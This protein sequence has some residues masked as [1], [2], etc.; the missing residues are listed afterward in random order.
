MVGQNKQSNKDKLEEMFEHFNDIVEQTFYFEQK[1]FELSNKVKKNKEKISKDMGRKGRVNVRVDD[2]LAFDVTKTKDAELSFYKSEL[3][4][5]L[6]KEKYKK[7]VNKTVKIDDLNGLIKLLKSYGI[8]PEE[9]K[10]YIS[11]NEEVDENLIEQLVDIGDIDIKDLQGCY[12]ADFSEEI[13]VRKI[14]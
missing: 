4:K 11:T 6:S 2:Y 7:V 3:K 1:I 5:N 9:F 13:K 14:K 10:Q 8:S 12:K